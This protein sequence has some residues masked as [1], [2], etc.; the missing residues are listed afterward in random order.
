MAN[1]EK[2][3]MERQF[4]RAVKACETVMKKRPYVKEF[5]VLKK[6]KFW[7]TWAKVNGYS[8]LVKKT[9]RFVAV[10]RLTFG[11]NSGNGGDLYYSVSNPDQPEI[12]VLDVIKMA[13]AGWTPTP[14]SKLIDTFPEYGHVAK[15]N[16]R[17]VKRL[18]D[19]FVKAMEVPEKK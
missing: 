13:I 2:E 12:A 11:L 17:K 9:H 16:F 18:M 3:F 6:D 10:L 7:A 4:A 1:T 14:D 5:T 19:A 8:S 15:T